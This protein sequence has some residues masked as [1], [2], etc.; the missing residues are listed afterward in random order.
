MRAQQLVAMY[1]PFVE[2]LSEVAAA[3]VLGAGAG[4]VTNGRLSSGALIAFLLYL[5]LFFSPIQ[6]LSQVF[7]T[8][9]QAAVA[10]DRIGEL[11]AVP[12][13]TPEAADPVVAGR[14][15]GEIRFESVS[16]TYPSMT[17]EALSGVDLVVAA[18]ETVA[19][20]G[21]T[22][23][24]KSTLEKLVARYY[25]ATGGRVVVDGVDVRDYDLA[26][27]RHQL[28]VVPQ[29]PFL[30][31]GSIRDNIAFGRA[32]ATDVEVEAAAR[33]V[34]AHATIA[35]QSGGYLHVV[36]ERG[37]SLSSGERQL[38]A[39][40]RAQLV[41]PAI[42]LLDEA[43]SNLD[44]ATEAQVNAAMGVVA[45][46]RTT[47]VIAHRL[48]TAAV[49]DR[50]VVMDRGR[51]VEVGT[52]RELLATHGRYAEMWHTFEQPNVPG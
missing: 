35:R 26:S 6:Q 28:G 20:V 14:L 3:I 16:F 41:D 36:S 40:A 29:E 2:M 5:D 47:M 42:L 23:A 27:L 22:G 8:Y 19:V 15:I 46:G 12:V 32:D 48:P 51:I 50:V 31:A 13:L 9:Q 21:E 4:L 11:M 34:G 25:D 45:S 37:Q 39:L 52:H 1:F 49:A 24:G 33:A 18:G 17:A 38:L 43:T 44:L 10:L 30:F 7:D